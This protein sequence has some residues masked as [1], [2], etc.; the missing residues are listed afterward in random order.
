LGKG[1]TLEM[2]IKEISNERKEKRNSLKAVKLC[3]GRA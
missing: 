1:I 2:Q 3:L